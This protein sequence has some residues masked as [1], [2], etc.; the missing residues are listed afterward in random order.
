MTLQELKDNRTEIIEMINENNTLEIDL[1]VVMAK[2]AEY[3]QMGCYFEYDSE[4]ME[5]IVKDSISELNSLEASKINRKSE[6]IREA[7]IQ[8]QRPSSMR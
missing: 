3:A 6:E 5:Q 4:E 1:K 7:A 8:A 2:V